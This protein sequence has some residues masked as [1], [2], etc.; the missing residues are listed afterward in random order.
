MATTT[1][2]PIKSTAGAVPIRNEK[3][4]ITMQKVKVQR[5][6]TGKR[7][8]YA[9]ESDEEEV[10]EEDE[11]IEAEDR[12]NDEYNLDEDIA[13]D[14]RMKRLLQHQREGYDGERR[15]EVTGPEILSYGDDEASADDM[16]IEDDEPANVAS[17]FVDESEESD[18]DLDEDEIERRRELMRQRAKE[19]L[20]EEDDVLE[21][22]DERRSEDA[23]EDES[24]EYEEYSDSEEDTGPRLKPVF[25]RKSDRGTI[26]SQRDIEKEEEMLARK[27]EQQAILRRQEAKR[28][29][30]TVVLEELKEEQKQEEIENVVNTDD[31]NDEEEYEAW[32]VRELNR[33]KKDRDEREQRE[34]EKQ[35]LERI[36][37]MT[38]EERRLE[39]LKNPKLQVNKGPKGRYKFLQKY[40]HKGAFFMDDEDNLYKRDYAEPTLEDHFDKTILPKVMQVKHFGRSGRTK[41][42]H[43]VDQD[44]TDASSAWAQES[45]INHKFYYSKAAG[46]KNLNQSSNKKK[47]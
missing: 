24:S 23:E 47:K 20:V 44:T 28:L 5:Y 2:V 19:R 27:E 8:L 36:R 43:L 33:I 3:G 35:E 1:S 17:R 4:E 29:V 6:V 45:A 10:E 40:Y 34:K 12:F 31:D 46:R 32:K 25:V 14:R 16:D 9:P 15:R 13:R 30:N 37:N 41:Y 26:K 38:D 11:F 18:E 42:T 21:L 7:P 22:E 39:F